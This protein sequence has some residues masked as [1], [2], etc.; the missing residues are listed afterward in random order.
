M[1]EM[2]MQIPDDLAERIQPLEPWLP[3]VLELSL[4]GFQTR[5]AAVAT[6]VIRFLSQGPSAKELLN[7]HVSE[8]AQERLR[9][10]L[11]LNEVGILSEYEQAEL[12]ELDQIEHVIVMLKAQ[13]ADSAQFN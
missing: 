8:Q 3:T 10:L 5:A 4:I 1:I 11:A 7:F 13:T 9:R 6:E 2:Q 12:D